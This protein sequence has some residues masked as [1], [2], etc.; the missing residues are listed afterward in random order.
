MRF[1]S[2]CFSFLFS[3]HFFFCVNCSA[4][5]IFPPQS[6]CHVLCLCLKVYNLS[7]VMDDTN[8]LY[9]LHIGNGDSLSLKVAREEKIWGSCTKLYLDILT[10][11]DF[12]MLH[13]I[14]ILD[15]TC[16]NILPCNTLQKQAWIY[17]HRGHERASRCTITGIWPEQVSVPF[18]LLVCIFAVHINWGLTNCNILFIYQK[19]ISK[20]AYCLQ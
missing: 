2:R 11:N 10:S 20:G 6:A 19:L 8:L 13:C 7:I 3:L 5:L 1:P 17:S 18:Q 9:S 4:V 14:L 12:Y 15:S 16:H